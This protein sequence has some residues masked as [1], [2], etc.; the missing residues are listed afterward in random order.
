MDREIKI[1]NYELRAHPKINLI[2]LRLLNEQCGKEITLSVS[3]DKALAF[4][5]QLLNVEIPAIF[6]D[7]VL[8]GVV[9][10]LQGQLI[11]VVIHDIVEAKFHSRLH[12]ATH[13]KDV[14]TVEISPPDALSIALR[15]EVPVFVMESVFE[16]DLAQRSKVLNWYEYDKD[17]TLEVLNNATLEELKQQSPTELEI[18]LERAIESED[19]ELAE[20]LKSA[21]NN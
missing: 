10:A 13:E 2:G 15:A 12:I 19:Y 11:K 17:Y 16:K 8:C 3:P 6:L 21:M 9:E 7:D 1:E 18:F 14:F 5:L 4:G 20:K